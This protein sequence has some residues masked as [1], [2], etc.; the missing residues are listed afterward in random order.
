MACTTYLLRPVKIGPKRWDIRW[1]PLSL[2]ESPRMQQ[3]LERRMCQHGP[4]TRMEW[5]SLRK[6]FYR[7]RK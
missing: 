2:W 5:R 6:K 4:L 3:H 1:E 7:R